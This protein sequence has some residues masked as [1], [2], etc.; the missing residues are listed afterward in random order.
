MQKRS[1]CEEKVM[2]VIWQTNRLLSYK[3]I[4]SGVNERFGDSWKPETVCM[5][6]ERLR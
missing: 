3:E 2:L 5:F 4:Q 1:A 6:I